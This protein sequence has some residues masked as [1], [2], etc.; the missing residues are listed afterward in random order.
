MQGGK[1]AIVGYDYD[2]NFLT[3]DIREVLSSQLKIIG[4]CEAKSEFVSALNILANNA[5]IASPFITKRV[6]FLKV[7]NMINTIYDNN[8]KNSHIIVEY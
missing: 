5:V 7:D 4:I 3:A 2:D 6:N 8:E 1:V